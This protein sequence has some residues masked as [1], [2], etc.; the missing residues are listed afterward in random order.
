MATMKWTDS[1]EEPQAGS[2]EVINP[3]P[4]Q[5]LVST[6]NTPFSQVG[7]ASV[8]GIQLKLESRNSVC[9]WQ[10]SERWYHSREGETEQPRLT[11]LGFEGTGETAEEL[12]STAAMPVKAAGLVSALSLL[13]SSSGP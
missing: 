11:N 10:Q 1:A 7:K 5:I 8:K 3:H 13:N 12:Q 6:L 2:G 9:A 4:L